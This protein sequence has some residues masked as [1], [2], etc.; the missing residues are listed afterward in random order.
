M[1]TSSIPLYIPLCLY[2][3]LVSSLY[4]FVTFIFTFHYVSI[5]ISMLGSVDALSTLL[6]IPLCLYFNQVRLVVATFS[7]DFT[8]HYVSILIRPPLPRS[9]S[10]LFYHFL[11]TSSIARVRFCIF[12]SIF[13]CSGP[14]RLIFP[15]FSGFCRPYGFWGLSEVDSQSRKSVASSDLPQNSFSSHFS[16]LFLKTMTESSF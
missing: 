4:Y 5:L 15:V 12:G 13:V 3:N 14:F 6:Y 8:F 10:L 16:C 2:F 9:A 11:S 1:W 7:E